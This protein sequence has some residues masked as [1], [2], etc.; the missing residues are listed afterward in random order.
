M[1]R[2]EPRDEA[3]PGQLFKAKVWAMKGVDIDPL[4]LPCA[5]SWDWGGQAP[6]IESDLL[7]AVVAMPLS[8]LVLDETSPVND[9]T[10]D[11]TELNFSMR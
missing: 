9:D 10:T 1:N 11:G 8:S 5:S 7:G 4:S 2:I 3:T 6:R